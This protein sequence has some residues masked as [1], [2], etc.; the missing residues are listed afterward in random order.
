MKVLKNIKIDC[1]S[2]NECIK[3]Q[4]ALFEL[5][6]VWAG[7]YDKKVRVDP[8]DFHIGADIDG[9]TIK[10]LFASSNGYIS[11][12]TE[13]NKSLY[14]FNKNEAVDVSV[15]FSIKPEQFIT[16]GGVK[17]AERYIKNLIAKANG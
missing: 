6:Y 8:N 1:N 9:K 14:E 11:F 2:T 5:G 16:I 10:Y 13:A 7:A 4:L 12:A 17:Y 3:A 15:E